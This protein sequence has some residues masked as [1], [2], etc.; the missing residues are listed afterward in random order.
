MIQGDA[1]CGREDDHL[2]EGCPDL[3]DTLM[4]AAM[5]VLAQLLVDSSADL[6]S[7]IANVC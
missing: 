1:F 7:E 2:P 4:P 3:V 6:C 5:P